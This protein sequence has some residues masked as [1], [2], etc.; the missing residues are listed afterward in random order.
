MTSIRTTAVLTATAALLALTACSSGGDSENNLG[1]VVAGDSPEATP[2]D[3]LTRAVT[4]YIETVTIPDT[5]TTW[6]MLSGRCQELWG[7]AEFDSRAEFAYQTAG[8]Q[9]IQT[10]T[11]DQI[12]GDLARVSYTTNAPIWEGDQE[13]WVREDGAWRLDSC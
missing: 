5:D 6:P 13:A 4:A 9:E 3:A 7:R 10:V 1:S 12:E 8:P 11:V 2:E